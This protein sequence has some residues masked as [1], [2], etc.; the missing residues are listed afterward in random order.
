MTVEGQ[1]LRVHAMPLRALDDFTM[2]DTSS[3]R[4]RFTVPVDDPYILAAH[5]P[6][7]YPGPYFLDPILQALR[8][9]SPTGQS[10]RLLCVDSLRI[11]TSVRPGDDLF[12]SL[13]VTPVGLSGR[14]RANGYY[15]FRDGTPVARVRLQVAGN[16]AVPAEVVRR[17]AAA[18]STARDQGMRMS[19]A[20]VRRY[21]P[22]RPPLLL[23]DEV[24]NIECWSR[25]CAIK[26]VSAAEWCYRHLADSL[27]NSAYGYPA[28]LT[29]ESFAE[30][31]VLL[32]NFSAMHSTQPL[33]DLLLHSV[34][35]Y[36]IHRA[37][38]PG[39]TMRN[40]VAI[41]RIINDKAVVVSGTTVVDDEI[42]AEIDTMVAAVRVAA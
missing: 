25:V 12:L 2:V 41:D 26:A 38:M 30:T 14:Q 5:Y 36:V 33:T 24:L 9:L 18:S 17:S 1:A 35:G 10:T 16:G 19:Q 6:P 21:L 8:L 11:S 22:M 39:E 42:V 7:V 13:S 28:S 3:L 4:A 37:V 20:G 40:E 29:L 15:W 31:A 34:R 23:I 27:P 32:W